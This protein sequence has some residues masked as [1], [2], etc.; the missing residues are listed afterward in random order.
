[1]TVGELMTRLKKIP[2]DAEILIELLHLPTEASMTPS[3]EKRH[4]FHSK[5]GHAVVIEVSR[6][7]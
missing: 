2:K 1:M 7:K 6:I 4:L 5:K 3:L